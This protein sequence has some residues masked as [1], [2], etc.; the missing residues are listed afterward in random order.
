MHFGEERIMTLERVGQYSPRWI[1]RYNLLNTCD[2]VKEVL[3]GSTLIQELLVL[4]LMP[5]S[6]AK[7]AQGYRNFGD[8]KPAITALE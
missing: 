4:R 8:G 5:V 2:R 7:N 1:S 6:T 3:V